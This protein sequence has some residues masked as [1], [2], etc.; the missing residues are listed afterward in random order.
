[1]CKKLLT[2]NLK[3][4]ETLVEGTSF[5][6]V[7]AIKVN[8]FELKKKGIVGIGSIKKIEEAILKK[9]SK[10]GKTIYEFESQTKGGKKIIFNISEQ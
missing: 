9:I 1:M 2:W 8:C 10:N 7:P 3:K 4:K 5:Q 6:F